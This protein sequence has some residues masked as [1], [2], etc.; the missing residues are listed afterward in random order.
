MGPMLGP[1]M[2]MQLGPTAAVG[3][4]WG[5]SPDVGLLGSLEPE[6]RLG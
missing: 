3:P 5:V 4:I 1:K 6:R 2:A